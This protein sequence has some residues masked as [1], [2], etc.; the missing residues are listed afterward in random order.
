MPSGEKIRVLI[1]DDFAMLRQVINMVLEKT[2]DIEVVGEAPDLEDALK[3]VQMLQPEVILMNDY[4]PPINSALAT[5][6]FR[7]LGV[8]AAILIITMDADAELIRQSFSSG[9]NGL[10]YKE[11]MGT[12]LPEAIRKVHNKEQFLS[13]MAEDTLADEEN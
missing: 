6:K 12:L 2:E 4:L 11:E 7:E 3:D 10:I 1:A 9:A 5:E 8:D 13:P